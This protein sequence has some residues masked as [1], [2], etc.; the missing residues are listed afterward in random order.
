MPGLFYRMSRWNHTRIFSD[1]EDEETRITDGE[2]GIEKSILGRQS[3]YSSGLQ[4]KA[5][6]LRSVVCYLF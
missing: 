4:S 3:K 5:S 1:L 6:L 2:F